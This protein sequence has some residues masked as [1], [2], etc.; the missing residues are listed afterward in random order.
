MGGLHRESRHSSALDWGPAG[1]AIGLVRVRRAVPESQ[2]RHQF[3]PEFPW[4]IPT[5]ERP[6]DGSYLFRVSVVGTDQPLYR[7][8]VKV[9]CGLCVLRQPERVGG[10]NPVLFGP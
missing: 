10:K 8:T 3:L 5:D 4:W 7:G 6:G 9:Q 2:D 1:T